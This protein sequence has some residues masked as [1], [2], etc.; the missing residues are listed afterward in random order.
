MFLQPVYATCGL[1]S[2]FEDLSSAPV[3]HLNE[4]AALDDRHQYRVSSF[5]GTNQML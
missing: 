1:T 5:P 4:E 2:A 3:L